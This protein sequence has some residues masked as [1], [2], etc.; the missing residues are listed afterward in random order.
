MKESWQWE[1]EGEG[2]RER[3]KIEPDTGFFMSSLC[4]P[5]Q[6]SP[7][8]HLTVPTFNLFGLPSPHEVVWRLEKQA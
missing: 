7:N 1:L 6:S 5:Y 2:R 4:F 3:D 8:P